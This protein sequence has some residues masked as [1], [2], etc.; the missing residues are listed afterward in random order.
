MFCLMTLSIAHSVLPIGYKQGRMIR[1]LVNNK[2]KN[3]WKKA[4]ITQFKLLSRH[5][6]GGPEKN[7]KNTQPDNLCPGRDFNPG[8]SEYEAEVL[9]TRP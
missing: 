3:M 8:P 1:W 9:T 6:P 7:H 2:L 4:V 5:F